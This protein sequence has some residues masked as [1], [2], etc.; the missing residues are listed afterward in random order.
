MM[1]VAEV[2]SMKSYRR[3]SIFT[4]ALLLTAGLAPSGNNNLILPELRAAVPGS[5]QS[6][7]VASNAT[8]TKKAPAKAEKITV[9]FFND[10]HGNLLPFKVKKDDGTTVETG[11]IAAIATLVKQIRAENKKQGIKTFLL[12]AGD[13][14]Q[15]TPMSTVFKGKPDIEI[16]NVMGVNAMTVGNHE[17]DFGLDNF[18]AMKKAAK[19]PI[20]SS[21]IIWKDSKKMVNE[22]L[23]SLPI[24]SKLTLTVIGATTT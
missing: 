22:P 24:T 21:N 16:L 9:L 1:S 10:L 20:I 18:L 4:L 12:V 11:G 13:V 8:V 6:T 14:L 5:A 19:F 23:A 7:R 17:F 15:G 3:L 2:E